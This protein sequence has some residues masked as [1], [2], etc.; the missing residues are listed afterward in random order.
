MPSAQEITELLVAWRDG[1]H[2]ALEKLIPFVYDELHRL[3][4]NYMRRERVGHT[5]QTSALINEA[6]IRLFDQ[7]VAWESRSHFFGIAARLMRQILV[8][9]ARSK[10]YAKRG[11][12]AHNVSPSEAGDVGEVRAAELV[13][14]DDA[15]RDLEAIDPQKS[16]IIELRFFGGFTIEET[17]DFLEISHATVEREWKAARAWL[18]REMS[19]T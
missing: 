4:R 18:R 16:R 7:K 8:D 3:A 17:A 11:G 2:G 1:D 15:L 9:H 14:L 13:A 6:Y 10:R 12:G 19:R 5:L